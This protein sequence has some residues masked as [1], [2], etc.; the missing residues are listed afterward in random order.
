MAFKLGL[1]ID[2]LEDQFPFRMVII[3][4]DGRVMHTETIGKKDHSFRADL[5]PDTYVIKFIGKAIEH[6][7]KLVV[8]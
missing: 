4:R 6:S 1:N 2:G 8:E 3:K 5:P 7:Q